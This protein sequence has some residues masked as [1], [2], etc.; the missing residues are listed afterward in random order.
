VDI[1]R[2]A[3]VAA[4]TAYGQLSSRSR[5]GSAVLSIA[6]PLLLTIPL[7]NGLYA[8]TESVA[9]VTRTQAVTYA[10]VAALAT[11]LRV[12]RRIEVRDAVVQHVRLGTIAYWFVWP[13]SP[14]RYY[15]IRAAGDLA[16][17]AA[18]AS[19]GFLVC[20]SLDVIDRPASLTAGSLALISA[21][22]GQVVIFL[23]ALLLD[24]C[25][26]WTTMNER[27]IRVV[28]FFQ[29][30]LTGGFVPLYFFPAWFQQLGHVL[31]FEA[32]IS[33][34]LSIYLGRAHGAAAAVAV[35]RQVAW[36][37]AL[38]AIGLMLWRRIPARLE[39]QGG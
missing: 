2:A 3:R 29:T 12:D 20:L 39:V 19:A 14:A 38:S 31:P 23:L 6:I 13:I 24:Q 7:W 1:R 11:T 30:L 15:V 33:T 27:I 26:F 10:V 21:A 28:R 25:C 34:P 9:G 4:V 18:W 37:L 32:V 5:L 16:Y 8:H 22:L 17:A 35:S 36:C